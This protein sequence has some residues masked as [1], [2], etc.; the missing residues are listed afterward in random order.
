MIHIRQP[1][2]PQL[3][4][5]QAMEFWA[6]LSSGLLFLMF[7]LSF[8]IT[9]GNWILR[10]IVIIAFFIIIESALRGK[11]ARLLLNVTVLLAI[12]SLSVLVVEFLPLV[13]LIILLALAR[14]LIVE[15]LREFRGR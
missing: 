1:E 4:I 3:E 15:N 2:T 9:P 12:M 14:L 8:V 11:I 6:A 13:V 7:A 5:N 10:S